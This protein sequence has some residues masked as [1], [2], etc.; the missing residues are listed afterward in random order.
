MWPAWVSRDRLI[1]GG[2]VLLQYYPVQYFFRQALSQGD[3]PF[4]NPYTFSGVPAFANLNLGF[5]YPPH[6]ALLWM[7]PIQGVNWLIGTHV[8][9]AGVAAA[10]C[11][12]RLGASKEG[13]FL[14]GIAYAL[15]SAAVARIWSGAMPFVEVN[16]WLAVATGLTTRILERRNAVYLAVAVALLILAGQAEIYLF[17][18]WWLP[19]FAAFS[20]RRRQPTAVISAVLLVGIALAVGLGLVAFQVLPFRELISVSYRQKGLTWDAATGWSLPP[21]QLLEVLSPTIFG[22][23]RGSYWPDEGH[24]WHEQLLYV[25]IVPL[26]AAVWPHG[27][28]RWVCLSLAAIALALAFGRYAPWYASV[29]NVLPGY[30]SFRGPSKHLT[31]AALALALAAGLGIHRLRGHRVAATAVGAAM[32]LFVASLTT[33]QWLHHWISILGG[34]D[35]LIQQSLPTSAAAFMRSGLEG[36][37]VILALA[38][39][40][41]LLPAPWSV[42]SLILLATLELAVTLHPFRINPTDP[43]GLLAEAQPLRGQ[44]RAAWVGAGGAGL[45]NYGP[46]INVTQPDGYLPLFNV[47]YG[48]LTTGADQPV[49]VEVGRADNPAIPLLGYSTIVDARQ[50]TVTVMSPPPPRAWVARCVWP[51]GGREVRDPDFPRH[52]CIARSTAPGREQP[53]P[54]GPASILAERPGWVMLVADGPGWLVTTEP[55]YPGWTASIEGQP[56]VLEPVDGALVGVELPEGTHTVTI[57]YRPAGLELGLLI[58]VGSALL[59][60]ALLKMNAG[61]EMLATFLGSLG[62]RLLR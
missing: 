28:R 46:L 36:A 54:P 8:V 13:Q 48:N 24:H 18:L 2:D 5:S 11:A 20:T 55:W 49:I 10:W 52:E 51:G 33:E 58:S 23:P 31:L 44:T 34:S 1:S 60:A 30:G 42:R 17:C 41:T 21:W 26:L 27:R 12:G 62:R 39:V 61:G 37:S 16:V 35:K 40:A 3:F 7:H 29:L 6:W 4:W 9:L 59:L 25:G 19:L 15:G 57:S 38:A 32:L 43:N 14:S 53:V 56:T 50:R 45:A 47:E 22:D